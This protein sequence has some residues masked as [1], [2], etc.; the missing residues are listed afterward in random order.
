MNKMNSLKGFTMVEVLVAMVLS[1]I[2]LLGLATAQLKSLQFATSSFNY[3]VSLIQANNAVERTWVNL[4]NLQNETQ[5]F[6]EA[7]QIIIRPD[8]NRIRGYSMVTA[9]LAEQ[10]FDN[11]LNI[12]VS[13]I[14]NR[15][16]SNAEVRLVENQAQINAQFPQICFA[17][18][19]PAV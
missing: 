5:P 4:C 14:D 1:T 9:P 12:T 6:D 3:T 2:T 10:P 19:A 16:A 17:P 15:L 13:W 7:Y 18:P 11:N 8:N